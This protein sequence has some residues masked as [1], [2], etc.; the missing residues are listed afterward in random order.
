MQPAGF[1]DGAETVGSLGGEVTANDVISHVVIPPGQLGTDYNFAELAPPKRAREAPSF[2][3][4][5]VLG[6]DPFG[7][8]D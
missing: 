8:E 7:E 4:A 5:P 2:L 1:A 3:F 6:E